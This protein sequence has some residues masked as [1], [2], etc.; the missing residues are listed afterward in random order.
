MSE[1]KIQYVQ[2]PL[3]GPL[4]PVHGILEVVDPD[5][6]VVKS[7]EGLAV[8]AKGNQKPIGTDPNEAELRRESRAVAIHSQKTGSDDARGG[9]RFSTI[10]VVLICCI[11]CGGC[12]L[13][14]IPTREDSPSRVERIASLKGFF[15]EKEIVTAV[16]QELLALAS[17]GGAKAVED[18][19]AKAGAE[20]ISRLAER[21]CHLDTFA[22]SKGD[23]FLY[24][25]AKYS[26]RIDIVY[27][28]RGDSAANFDVMAKKIR[29]ELFPETSGYVSTYASPDYRNG[30]TEGL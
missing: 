26:L 24:S 3:P 16:Q 12:G 27:Q 10:S 8:D 1:W 25:Y 5:G 2:K 28:R 4:N 6:H 21:R 20:C 15:D 7:F 22:T 14:P 29:Y 18:D 23:L 30:R 19:L 13:L 9:A 11:G 17:G